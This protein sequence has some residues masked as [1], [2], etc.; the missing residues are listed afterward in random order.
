[1]TDSETFVGKSFNLTDIYK[2]EVGST[3]MTLQAAEA[4]YVDAWEE[5]ARDYALALQI[6]RSALDYCNRNPVSLPATANI[7]DL[8]ALLID[9]VRA[10]IRLSL[11]RMYEQVAVQHG[12]ASA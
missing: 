7:E 4:L 2:Q 9:T 11:S 6:M 1:M 10:Q 5:Q 3:R 8:D 12:A